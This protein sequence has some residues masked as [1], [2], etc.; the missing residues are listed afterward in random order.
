MFLSLPVLWFFSGLGSPWC[1]QALDD[2]CWS[3]ML[4]LGQSIQGLVALW[5]KCST[6]ASPWVWMEWHGWMQHGST[7]V[8]IWPLSAHIK[9]GLCGVGRLILNQ[10]LMYAAHMPYLYVPRLSTATLAALQDFRL[11]QTTYGIHLQSFVALP[12]IHSASTL[13]RP[14]LLC[15]LQGRRTLSRITTVG[16]C[17]SAQLQGLDWAERDPKFK[18]SG[19]SSAE[20]KRKDLI[21]ATLMSTPD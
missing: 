1:D 6:V 7:L 3:Q 10:T 17:R 12:S 21:K 8:G 13:H 9:R 4:F 14:S 2:F 5:K 11:L 15:A 16:A 19:G 18:R 20:R